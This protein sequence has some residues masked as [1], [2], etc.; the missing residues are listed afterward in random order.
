[1]RSCPTC[2]R[3]FDDSVR[4]CPDDGTRLPEVAAHATETSSQPGLFV[5]TKLLPPRPA[6][7]LLQ[8]PRLV[9]RL[10]AN[11]AHPVTLV[12]ANA[13]SGKTTLVADFVR[14]H[15]PRFVWY[16][17]DRTDVDPAVFLG[18]VAI[19]LQ[20]V[21]PGFGEATLSYLKQSAGEIA[22]HPERAVDVL[23][24]EIL[25]AV[26]QK[27]VLVLDDYHHLGTETAVHRAVDRLL[28]YLPDTLHVVIISREMM[29][30]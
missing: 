23:I 21:T 15:V 8:R 11:L 22:N 1:M 29:T 20:Q 27:L 3:T 16:Q 25:D 19:G 4:F 13:G 24:N 17:L 14:T 2:A 7:A 18:Y 28:A 5:R 6:P 26:D 30:T 10:V 9:E 12:T